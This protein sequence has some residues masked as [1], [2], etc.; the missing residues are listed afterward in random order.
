MSGKSTLKSL[1]TPHSSI[2]KRAR[3]LA[4]SLSTM[5]ESD[6]TR[7]RRARLA[8][9]PGACVL[10]VSADN[11]HAFAQGSISLVEADLWAGLEDPSGALEACASHALSHAF[12]LRREL[13]NFKKIVLHTFVDTVAQEK[14]LRQLCS[15][16]FADHASPSSSSGTCTD[17]DNHVAGESGSKMAPSSCRGTCTDAENHVAG[18]SGTKTEEE[19]FVHSARYIAVCEAK[20]HTSSARMA[21]NDVRDCTKAL[22]ALPRHPSVAWPTKLSALPA[23]DGLAVA[24]LLGATR[25]ACVGETTGCKPNDNTPSSRALSALLESAASAGLTAD[26]VDFLRCVLIARGAAKALGLR[27]GVRAYVAATDAVLAELRLA[28]AVDPDRAAAEAATRAETEAAANAAGAAAVSAAL[29]PVIRAEKLRVECAAAADICAETSRWLHKMLREAGTGTR[30]FD[31]SDRTH[32]R[33]ANGHAS[34]SAGGSGDGGG[35]GGAGGGDPRVRSLASF[36]PSGFDLG[37]HLRR[38]GDVVRAYLPRMRAEMVREGWPPPADLRRGL[39]RGRQQCLGCSN[40]FAPLWVHR[41]LCCACEEARR[42]RGVCPFRPALCRGRAFCPHL[43][44]CLACEEYSC[45]AAGCRL[46]RGDGEAVAV[47]VGRLLPRLRLLLLDFDRTLA[48]TRSG[49]DPL[50]GAHSMDA[51]LL[52][53]ASTSGVRTHVLTRNPHRLSIETF[54]AARGVA[55][56]VHCVGG[57]GRMAKAKVVCELVRAAA[58]EAE[59]APAG[60]AAAPTPGDA[61]GD[62]VALFVDDDVAEHHAVGEAAA[63]LPLLRVL[64]VR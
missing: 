4:A 50:K 3:G 49:S 10:D 6:A 64:F 52:T 26:E 33:H 23:T 36:A 59:G 62:V 42:R 43:R 27:D 11:I 19:A 48:S 20:A 37:A 56:T 44:R 57:G 54:I 31:V 45:E 38:N 51:E 21:L 39:L 41:G 34:G 25:S 46:V 32:G 2:H 7:R 60:A 55:A 1:P 14:H 24:K 12:A 63:E 22:C 9:I 30:L 13:V 61:E 17:A 16:F 58:A 8:S 40:G 15:W 47:L 29:R 53:A 28:A 35:G 18:E 5:K